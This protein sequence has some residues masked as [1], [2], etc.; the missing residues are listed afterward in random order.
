MA[1]LYQQIRR[2]DG[3]RKRSARGTAVLVGCV[4]VFLAVVVASV[5]WFGG[6]RVRFYRFVGML[7]NSTVYAYENDSLRASG[8]GCDLRLS[9]ENIYGLYNY[10][11][12]IGQDTEKLTVPK[13]DP[14]LVLDYGNG[15]VMYVWE[16]YLGKQNGFDR[17]GVQLLFTDADGSRYTYRS[18]RLSMGDIM[19]RYLSVEKNDPWVT[20]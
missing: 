20:E 8:Q 13:E 5:I 18:R 7:S 2:N 19:A 10:I 6:A 3:R 17:Y 4:A 1:G 11:T 12:A 15:A 9:D 14:D 16:V